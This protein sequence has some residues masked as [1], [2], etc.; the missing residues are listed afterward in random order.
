MNHKRT[1]A[2]VA[3]AVRTIAHNLSKDDF[4]HTMPR[5]MLRHGDESSLTCDFDPFFGM[6]QV[7]QNFG[8]QVVPTGAFDDVG[9]IDQ[10]ARKGQ[11]AIGNDH[12]AGDKGFVKPIVIYPFVALCHW[13]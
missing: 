12:S 11:H 3:F 7:I 10:T 8:F 13:Q 9:A 4:F 2:V 6:G 5:S 1:S